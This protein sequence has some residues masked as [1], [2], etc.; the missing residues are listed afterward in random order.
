M[1]TGAVPERALIGKRDLNGEDGGVRSSL[2]P[3]P[4]TDTSVEPD[5]QLTA[6][7]SIGA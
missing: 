7:F 5:H 4:F 3:C 2:G 6:R 1:C